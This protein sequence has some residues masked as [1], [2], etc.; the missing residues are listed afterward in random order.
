MDDLF[1]DEEGDNMP[2]NIDDI[3]K[4]VEQIKDGT[5]VEP[6]KVKP[7]EKNE[8]KKDADKEIPTEDDLFKFIEANNQKEEIKFPEGNE[9]SQIESK[10]KKIKVS[11]KRTDSF[12]PEQLDNLG[13]YGIFYCY[14]NNPASKEKCEPEK[15]ICPNC[16][17][18]TQKLYGLK[19]HYLINSKGRVCTYKRGKIYC[20]GKFSKFEDDYYKGKNNVNIKYFYN[21]VC[22][23]SGQCESC[24]SLTEKMDNY[25]SPDLM[26]KLKERDNG[27]N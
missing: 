12:P 11:E 15:T 13:S 7:I 6:P 8:E 21:Y 18:K 23:H 22:G 14:Q 27:L 3:K 19:P 4:K 24:K 1:G 9:L 2:G 5:Y 26:K 17:K 10:F 16:M 20:K 25:F